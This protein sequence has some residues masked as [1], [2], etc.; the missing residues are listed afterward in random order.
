MNVN[1]VMEKKKEEEGRKV[2][3]EGEGGRKKGGGA[4]CR[5][6]GAGFAKRFYLKINLF[7]KKFTLGNSTFDREHAPYREA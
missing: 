7:L 2:G 6:G 5:A 4:K 1:K 3:G